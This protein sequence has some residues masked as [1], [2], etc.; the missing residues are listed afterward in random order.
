MKTKEYIYVQSL[1]D[2]RKQRIKKFVLVLQRSRTQNEGV[3]AVTLFVTPDVMSK[4]C[5]VSKAYN[6]ASYQKFVGALSS[7]HLQGDGPRL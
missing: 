2:C 6:E 4:S 1:C 3:F 5:F 7:T